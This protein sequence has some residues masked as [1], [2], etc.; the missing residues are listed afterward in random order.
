MNAL[1]LVDRLRFVRELALAERRLRKGDA[2]LRVLDFGMGWGA[3]CAM[4]MAMGCEV[5]GHESSPVRIAHAERAGVKVLSWDDLPQHPMDFINSEQVFEHLADPLGALTH[6]ASALAPGGLLKISVP[7][8]ADIKRR[9]AIGDWDAGEDSPRSLLSITP[10]QHVNCF[11]R[12]SLVE[13]ARR[14]GLAPATLTLSELYGSNADIIAPGNLLAALTRP[15]GRRLF[16]SDTYL[17]FE[18]A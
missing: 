12:R 1:D 4:A 10:L 2:Q 17:F 7:D 5:H 9:L 13:L 18:R 6:L 14:A 15:L 3:W 11:S 8:G 16:A